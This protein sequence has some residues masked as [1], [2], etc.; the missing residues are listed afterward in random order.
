MSEEDIVQATPIPRTRESLAAD[1]QNL[2]VTAGTTLLV[3]SSLRSLGWV[4]GGPVAVV[5]ALMDVVTPTG[6]LVVPTHTSGNSDPAKWENPPVPRAWWS[7]IYETMPAFDPLTSPTY[8]MGKIVETFRTWPTVMRSN[9]PADSFA[10][11]GRHAEYITAHHNLEYGL[12]EGSPLA[13]L[14][15]VDAWVLLLGVGYNRNTSFHLAEYRIPHTAQTT[16]G[17]SIMEQGER[18]WRQYRDIEINSDIFADIG[19]AFEQDTRLVKLGRVGSA[20]A[21]LFPQRLAV[22]FAEKWLTQ[23]GKH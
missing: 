3:H 5:Q 7:V 19:D 17:A 15:D 14:Y 18:V 1:L 12:G 16:L 4:S 20:E 22:D 9:H 21:R 2:G 6:T 8:G 10:A 23:N 13:R 11:W